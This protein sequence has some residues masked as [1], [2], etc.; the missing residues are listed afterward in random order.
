M[1]QKLMEM[2]ES[3]SNNFKLLVTSRD[4]DIEVDGYFGGSPIINITN[5][6]VGVDINKYLDF[7]ITNTHAT[8]L[9]SD[10]LREE[11]QE[12]LSSSTDGMFLWASLMFD[13]LE[14]QDSVASRK[15]V[16]LSS[17]IDI[18]I[19]TQSHLT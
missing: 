6:D 13:D 15:P 18:W 10:G 3:S 19:R 4:S 2:A 9:R 11:I 17:M 14:S 12:K 7:R 16:R 8:H 1:F 5:D